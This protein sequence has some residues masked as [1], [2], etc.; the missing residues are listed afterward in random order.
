LAGVERLVTRRTSAG[1]RRRRLLVDVVRDNLRDA[2]LA[3]EYGPGDLLPP[4]AD[5]AARYEVSRLTLREA[6][7]GLAEEGF[8]SR[9]QG[10]GT[11]ITSLP[12]LQNNLSENFGVTELIGGLGLRPGGEVLDVSIEPAS[13]RV[14]RAIDVQ[15]HASVTRL[16]RVRTA[17]DDPI[18]YSIEYVATDL[19]ADAEA[20]A[21]HG[22]SLYALLQAAGI[23][24]HHGVAKLK[25]VKADRELAQRLG[26]R[27][28]GPLLFL[29]QVDYD[30][31]E[32]PHLLALEWYRT[33]LVE[34][35]VYRRGVRGLESRLTSSK[36]DGG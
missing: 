33:D 23:E 21:R 15:P 34:L 20:L 12:R 6:V 16:E 25:A 36:P 9:K 28:G 4:E 26:I 1:G 8:V 7:R 5:L 32:H 2:I 30:S 24:L 22:G 29:E 14:A 17:E 10:V 11:S 35:S 27:S 31:S 18:V 3:G 13:D 19:G